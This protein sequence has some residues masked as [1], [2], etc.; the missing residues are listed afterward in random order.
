MALDLSILKTELTTDPE[1][2]GYASF[3]DRGAA[4]K[5]N[6]AGASSETIEVE[7]V[8]AVDIQGAVVGSEFSALSATAQR[9]W[10]AIVGLESVPVKN[11]NL[12]EQI[13]DI[14][15]AGTTTRTNL[16]ALQTKSATR[17]EVLFGEGVSV[18]QSDVQ[19]AREM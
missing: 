11:T 7:E 14:W 2:L 3:S 18:S 6:E 1:T 9:A 4:N 5:L 17:A 10:L 8:S 15:G 16:A 19:K 13:L 12:R